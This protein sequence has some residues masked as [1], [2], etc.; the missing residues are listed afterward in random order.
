MVQLSP[1]TRLESWD[2][3]SGYHYS[4]PAILGFSHTHLSGTGCADLGDI[5][6]TPQVGEIQ[7][8]KAKDGYHCA[9]SHK[10]ESARPGY[11]TVTL[12]DPKVKVELTATARAGFHRYTFPAEEPAHLV[13]DLDRGIGSQPAEGSVTVE[14][15]NLISG[16]RRSH[17]W[18]ADKTFYFVAEFSRPFDGVGINVNGK[19]TDDARA[20]KGQH[21]VFHIDYRKGGE[22]IL[23]KIGISGTSV[24]GARRT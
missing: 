7:P 11:Y 4:D 23:V 8:P 2:G 20:G 13:F 17:G 24:E 6:V 3:C 19:P 21:V 16:Y 9:F 10:D 14:K 15:D 1:D 5:R 18:A 12:Q 22:P